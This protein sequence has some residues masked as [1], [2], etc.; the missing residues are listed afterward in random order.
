MTKGIFYYFQLT[1]QLSFSTNCQKVDQHTESNQ[2]IHGTKYCKDNQSQSL[3]WNSP[4]K[5][6]CWD[7]GFDTLES[8]DNMFNTW[9]PRQNGRHFEDDI[10]K[11]IFL[12]ENVW[13]LIKMSLNFVPKGS[14]NNFL[15][16]V[17]IMAW[18][19]PGDKPLSEAMMVRLT[20]HLC[21]THLN[22]LIQ[23]SKSRS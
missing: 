4:V 8:A 12:N 6:S 5:Y 1:N 3:I 16:L 22:E 21:I 19:W 11:C 2:L 17:Q 15:S 23:Y 18:H 9:R 13:T 14:I 10:F 20:M 7:N